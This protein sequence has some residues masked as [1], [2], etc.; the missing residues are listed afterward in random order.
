MV[1]EALE[2]GRLLYGALRGGTA[3]VLATV[4]EDGTP[5]TALNTWIVAKDDHTVALAVDT[6]STAY[7]NI[8]AGRTKVAFEVLADDLILSVRGAATMVKERLQG[9]S[10]PCE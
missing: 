8:S 9:V 6:R 2:L 4:G 5:S 3:V 7:A 10:F 1:R